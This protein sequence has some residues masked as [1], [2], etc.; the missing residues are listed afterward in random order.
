MTEKL[1][2]SLQAQL[3]E[4]PTVKVSSSPIFTLDKLVVEVAA[5]DHGIIILTKDQWLSLA[6]NGGMVPLDDLLNKDDFP[7][8]VVELPVDDREGKKETH[9]YAVPVAKTKWM[10]DVGYKG[11]ELFAF[12]HPRA[13]HMDQAKQVLK[14][15]VGK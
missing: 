4:S 6:Q 12:I 2:T 3:G 1:E 8:G 14:T 10:T 15:I 7:E 9:L 11:E 5:G 13:P